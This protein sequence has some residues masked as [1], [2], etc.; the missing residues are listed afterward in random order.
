MITQPF[1]SIKEVAEHLGVEYKTVYRLIR[2]GELAAAKIGGIY[3]LRQADVDAYVEQQMAITRQKALAAQANKENSL[4]CSFCFRYIPAD[5]TTVGYCQQDNCSEPLCTICWQQ[6]NRYCQHH[7]PTLADKLQQAEQA[8]QAGEVPLVLTAIMARQRELN[9]CNRFERKIARLSHVTLPST[10]TNQKPLPVAD[11]LFDHTIQDES[12]FN[13]PATTTKALTHIP[14]NRRSRYTFWDKAGQ[15]VL[16]IEAASQTRLI[17]YIRDGFDTAPL[18]DADLMNWLLTYVTAA[19]QADTPWVVGIASPT[20]WTEA[21]QALITGKQ[22][23]EAWA[24]TLV[25]PCLI[26]LDKR[27]CYAATTNSFIQFYLSLFTL[28]LPE[29][30]IALVEQHITQTVPYQGSLA[31]SDI[32]QALMVDTDAITTA[33]ARLEA[34]GTYFIED[35]AGIGRVIARR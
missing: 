7:Q 17:N 20:G 23:G 14:T 34:A 6:G 33:F 24:H 3:R 5:Q 1:L 35:V 29:E 27:V 18:T 15:Q 32:Q 13:P 19:E 30:E 2:R 8:Q 22:P 4:R 28:M 21:A 26:D 31:A 11:L 12:H 16:T 10:S 25:H 9:F